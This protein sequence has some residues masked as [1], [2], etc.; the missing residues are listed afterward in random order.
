MPLVLADF[1]SRYDNIIFDMDGV[2]TSEQN[3]WDIAALTVYEMLTDKHYY[4]TKHV[5]IG[6]MLSRIGS[7]RADVFYSDRLIELFKARG[8]NSNWD[9][10]YLTLAFRLSGLD[11]GEAVYSALHE[12]EDYAFELY[13]KAASILSMSLNL[14]YETCVRG[15]SVWSTVMLVFQEWYLGAKAFGDKYNQSPV[16]AEK[17]GM[18]GREIPI[19]PEKELRELLALLYSS[20]KMLAIGT[21]RPKN[22]LDVPLEMWDIRRY[23]NEDHIID[24]NFVFSAENA[25]GRQLTK[26]HPYMFI[27]AL[28]GRDYSDAKILENKFDASLAK[29]TL[30]VGDAGADIFAAHAMGAAFAA[31]LTGIKGERERGFFAEHGAEHILPS[32]LNLGRVVG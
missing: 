10:A 17:S 4:G 25:C 23:F 26:P 27:K 31:V 5:D 18:S 11:S 1:L 16:R 20:G 3:Y 2:I 6:A 13:E 19:V 8:V 12:T 32:V 29:R 15:G 7:I 22:E 21:G 24:Y 28:L 14:D 9:L 30:V